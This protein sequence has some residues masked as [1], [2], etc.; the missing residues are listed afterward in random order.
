MICHWAQIRAT[1]MFNRPQTHVLAAPVVLRTV[2]AYICQDRQVL[3]CPSWAKG[4]ECAKNPAYIFENCQLSCGVCGFQCAAQD[5][6]ADGC[7][8]RCVCA[9]PDCEKGSESALVG[10]GHAESLL[11]P[12]TNF[13]YRREPPSNFHVCPTSG[14]RPQV[15]P[16]RF[17]KPPKMMAKSASFCYEICPKDAHELS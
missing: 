4:N 15:G 17:R 1:F 2:A 6:T 12:G 16:G 13:R 8:W 14:R 10:F 9:V 7:D 11:P 5:R 3:L